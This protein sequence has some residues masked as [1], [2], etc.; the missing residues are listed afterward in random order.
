MPMPSAGSH[1]R[2]DID[3]P[4]LDDVV[5]QQLAG[6]RLDILPAESLSR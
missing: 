2:A 1:S 4:L 5:G 6:D 3:P